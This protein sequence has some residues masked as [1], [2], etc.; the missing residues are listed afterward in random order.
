[1]RLCAVAG[2]L[3]AVGLALAPGAAAAATQSVSAQYAQ[4]SPTPVDVLPGET[5]EWTNVSPRRHT[6][7]ADDGSFES[8]DG[9]ESGARFDHT[10]TT[11]GTFA[12]HCRIHAGMVGEIDVR[13]VTLDALP[14]AAVAPGTPV[15]FSGRTADPSRPVTIERNEGGGGFQP[16]ASVTPAADGA[17]KATVTAQATGDYRASAGPDASESRRLLVVE[18]TVTLRATRKGVRATVTPSLPNARVVLEQ[19]LRERFGWWPATFARLDYVS[20]ADFRVRRPARV[21][22]ALLGRDGWTPVATSAV[23]RLRARR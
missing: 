17:W 4:F 23:L 13:R 21:R 8:G 14:A 20:Q 18:R 10:F 15:P 3:S 19:D 9:F 12:Y 5:V 2:A 22:V 7:T 16:V 6:V 1:M 11:V